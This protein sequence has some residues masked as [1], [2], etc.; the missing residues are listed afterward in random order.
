MLIGGN[1][2][3]WKEIERDEELINLI[4]DKEKDF[5]ERYI[6]GNEIPDMDGSDATSGFLKQKY[7]ESF[8]SEKH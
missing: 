4:I 8:D 2:F 1:R 7:H 6:L 5:W 3:I